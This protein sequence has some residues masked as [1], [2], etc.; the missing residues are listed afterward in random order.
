MAEPQSKLGSVNISTVGDIKYDDS[1]AADV[2]VNRPVSAA[3]AD[4]STETP[5]IPRREKPFKFVTTWRFWLILILGQ[6]LSWCI[7]STNTF[8]EYLSLAGANIPAFQTLFNYAL[9]SLV[10]T[11]WTLYRYGFKKW[12]RLLWKDGWKY[13]VLGFADVQGV[14]KT[15]SVQALTD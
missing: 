4:P 6:I 1:K 2:S 15:L 3:G 8:T 5:P 10:Y 7:V 11:S 12:L 9:L 13:F 14:P